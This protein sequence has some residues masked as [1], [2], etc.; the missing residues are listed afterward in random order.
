ME[1][2]SDDQKRLSKTAEQPHINS[3]YQ[4]R[5][6]MLNKSIFIIALCFFSTTALAVDYYVSPSGRDTAN[7]LYAQT[8]TA[9]LN[10]PF[11][12]LTYAQQVIRTL[13]SSGKLKQ[14]VTVHIQSGTYT[15]NTPLSFDLRDAGY[16][17]S[18]IRWQGDPGATVVISGGIAVTCTQSTTSS[19][20]TCP[21]KTG[22]IP[23]STAYFDT[24]RILGNTPRF[25]LFVNDQ[26]LDLAR[27]PNTGWA[28][29][30]TPITTNTKF[31]AIETLPSL[32]G[33]ISNAQVHIFPGNDWFDQYI[34]VS[35]IAAASNAI[36]LSAATTYPLNAGRR[37]YIQNLP[38]LLDAPGE[39]I[40][41][42]KTKIVS[43]IP[44][45][46]V[47]P[48]SVVLSSQANLLTAS[49]LSY[50]TFNNINFKYSTG[51]AIKL[52]NS[53]NVTLDQLNINN[54]G[55]KGVQVIGGN[56][57]RLTN[58]NIHHTGAE[59]ID[60]SGG[61]RIKLTTS[62]HEI[63]NNYIHHVSNTILT[64]TPAIR[65]SGVGIDVTHNLLEQG[66]GSAILIAGNDHFIE[67]NDV[68]H[69]C[70]QASDCGAIYSGR[71]WSYRGNVVRY[72]SIHDIIG[73]GLKSF[74]ATTNTATYA[75][76]GA[77]GIYLDDAASSFDIIGNLLNNAG[78]MAIQVGG[79]RDNNID[80][81]LIITNDY[82]IWVDN[83]WPT[84]D[85]TQNETKL[86]SVPYQ[87][88]L[89]R[90]KYPLLAKAMNNKSW[91]E[92]NSIQHNIMISNDTKGHSLRY[93]LPSNSTT[94]ANNLVWSTTGQF[95][96]DYNILDLSQSA[97]GATWQ[98][99]IATSI[100][101]GSVNAD[102]CV[103][104][105]GN[106]VSFCSSSPISQIGFIP[107]PTDMGLIP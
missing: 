101:Q 10:G 32:T 47:T 42:T 106:S 79:G 107:L 92:G 35:S 37:F 45:A 14:P 64:Y 12:T 27:W 7:G 57:I 71:D 84:Y 82:A 4:T 60:I 25:E 81:N 11:K 38:A 86:S 61:D 54:I 6:T 48:N 69:F 15:L 100:E 78:E 103:N 67:K 2:C 89:W 102:P 91:P 5:H 66:A 94:I 22:S 70:L 88:S 41:D 76:F 18:P 40:Y 46:G 105:S 96:A 1:N 73:Y 74:D 59:G 51:N 53:N 49:S 83:R 90:S 98:Q 26:R 39:W 52:L 43:F 99:W 23:V 8:N 93:Q 68:H 63:Y 30:K 55:G 34:G 17:D 9:N 97:N 16:A 19:T 75:E 85:W 24:N 62:G 87:G 72:N 36:S 44:P 13:K 3:S 21:L 28:H 56:T 58:N 77:R 33:T 31:S 95:R 20:W 50:L 80:N 29:I 104:V 65:L